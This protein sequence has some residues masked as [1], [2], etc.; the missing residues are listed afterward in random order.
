MNMNTQHRICIFLSGALG[1][2]INALPAISALRG[3][4]RSSRIELVGNPSWLPL[5]EEARIVDQ[6]HSQ[7]ALP[8]SAGFLDPASCQ[9]P[10]GH[11]LESFELVLSWFG[12]REGLWERSLRKLCRGRV[13]V[14]PLHRYRDSPGHVSDY[15]LHTLKELGI[16]DVHPKIFRLDWHG[17]LEGADGVRGT[18]EHGATPFLC[19]HPGS[20]APRKNWMRERFLAVARSARE[21][22]G[23]GTRVLLGPAE[24]D[25]KVFWAA[26]EG[27][28][29]A[30]LS[31][32]TI[33]ALASVLAGA[34]L[35][36]GNDSGVTHLASCLGTPVIAL[37]GPTETVRWRP[38]GERVFVLQGDAACSPREGAGREACASPDRLSSISTGEVLEVMERMLLDLK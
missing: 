19:I 24:E 27:P 12:D 6:V 34:R 8:L 9:T 10:L 30:I 31:G 13:H 3:Q 21:R 28:D 32:L 18:E 16:Q 33:T 5:L 17:L 36:L 20:G 29:L 35:Y 2:F 25:Q 11:F 14:F 37:F 23:L 38:R 4:Y 22:W 26:V 15:F 7:E 1:D